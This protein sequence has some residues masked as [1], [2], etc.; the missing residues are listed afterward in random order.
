MKIIDMTCPKCGAVLKTDLDKGIAVCEYCETQFL[1]EKEDTLE[2]I[3]AKAQSRAYG[4]HKG[5]MEAEAEASKKQKYGKVKIAAIVFGVI[6]VVMIASNVVAEMAK[7]K[8]N[9]F[10]CIEVSFQGKDGE[11]E[12]AVNTVNGFE[13]IDINRIDFDISKERDLSQGENISIHAAS[14]DYRL[15]ETNKIYTVDGLDEY[16]TD[17]ENIPEEALKIIHMKAE[18]SLALNLENS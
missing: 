5:K 16:L 7:P 3:R 15:E 18:S 13:G 10:D 14:E 8:V 4:Y 11:G 17:L 12:I 2:E 1:I 9:P 6:V